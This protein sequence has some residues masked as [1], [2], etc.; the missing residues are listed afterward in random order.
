MPLAMQPLQAV[1]HLAAV[2][3]PARRRAERALQDTRRRAPGRAAARS[4]ARAAS[5]AWAASAVSG[6]RQA[7]R[8]THPGCHAGVVEEQERI[9]RVEQNGSQAAELRAGGQRKPEQRAQ[10][11][12]RLASLGLVDHVDIHSLPQRFLDGVVHDVEH[13]DGSPSPRH[14]RS[15]SASRPESPQRKPGSLASACTSS[16]RTCPRESAFSVGA[17][18][19]DAPAGP[20]A[21]QHLVHQGPLRGPL[22]AFPHRER[23]R[24][25]RGEGGVLG[26][27]P[28]GADQPLDQIGVEERLDRAA[29]APVPGQ[30]DPVA[31]CRRSMANSSRAIAS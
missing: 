27:E 31:G 24:V 13:R 6:Q 14:S 4:M 26:I 3:R 11:V 21:L 7:E 15:V 18:P 2:V 29:S 5:A 17:E 10:A 12:D 22:V 8:R 28:G 23:G 20:D 30:H 19:V 1:A 16:E 9:P 25:H